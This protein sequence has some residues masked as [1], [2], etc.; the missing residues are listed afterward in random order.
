MADTATKTRPARAASTGGPS[1]RRSAVAKAEARD[2]DGRF[3]GK[4]A[5]KPTAKPKAARKPPARKSAGSEYS[6]G[7]M[8]GAAAAGLAVGLAANVARKFAVQA[9]TALAGDWDEAL[10]AEHKIALKLFDALE[11]TTEKN[12]IKRATLLMQLKHALSKH[13]L[14][15]ENVVYPAMREAGDIEAADHLNNDHGYVKQYL[16]ELGEMPKDDFGFLPKV[17]KFRADIET[18]M[19]EEEGT[20]FPRLKSMISAE[21]NKELTG[22]MN[23]EGLKL[24]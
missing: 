6:T 1:A 15:E 5:A 24:A 10:A 8:V 14:Q 4:P 9:P 21:K 7:A 16:Y 11:A 20:L 18:H 23:K 17:R 3:E 13:A 22:L 12:G 2:S 19:R